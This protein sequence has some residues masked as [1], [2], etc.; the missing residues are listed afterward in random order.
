MVK[1][2][3]PED[4]VVY[5]PGKVTE[6]VGVKVGVAVGEVLSENM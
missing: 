5:G 4:R 3:A 2:T 1:I 6:R